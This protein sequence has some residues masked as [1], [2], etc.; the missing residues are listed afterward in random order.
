MQPGETI[1]PG[2]SPDSPNGKEQTYGFQQESPADSPVPTTPAP[3][4][5]TVSNEPAEEAFNQENS[6]V[7]W[8]ASE[9]IDH[10][11]SAQ[12]YFAL[13]LVAVIFAFLLYLV[14][15]DWVSVVVVLIAVGL[16]GISGSKKPRTLEY[17]ITNAGVRIA[18]KLYAYEELKL[19]SIVTDGG[20]KSIQ[21][22]PLKR[23]MPTLSIYYPPELE[24]SIFNTLADFL[25][26]EELRHDPV[27]RLMK[28]LRF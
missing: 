7:D 21:I 11:K 1:T 5:E 8:T 19:F 25:P 10:Q 27:D 3:Q 22:L 9:Y 4:T 14:T 17:R 24:D 23:F 12:W 28:R 6:Y 16:F 26:H 20:M 2:G 18:D 13:A 15:Q